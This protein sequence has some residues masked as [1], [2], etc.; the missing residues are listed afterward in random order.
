MAHEEHGIQIYIK[1]FAALLFLTLLTV[2]AAFQDFGFL[3]IP[4]AVGIAITKATLVVL[5]FMHVI[6]ANKLLQ[7]FVIGGF[8][9]LT[10][11]FGFTYCDFL[12]RGDVWQETKRENTWITPSASHFDYNKNYGKGSYH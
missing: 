7:M 5:F 1:I 11:L 6:D 4:I 8:F 12:T 3:D 2:W 10:I 9:W